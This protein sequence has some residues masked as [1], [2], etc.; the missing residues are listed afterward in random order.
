MEKGIQQGCSIS[1][2]LFIFLIE[3]LA[4]QVKNNNDID[5]HSKKKSS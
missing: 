3:I 5:S 2:L 4:K 1:A